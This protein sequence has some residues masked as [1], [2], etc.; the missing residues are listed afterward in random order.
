MRIRSV[1][2]VFEDELSCAT[3]EF[4][5]S[6]DSDDSTKCIDD[7]QHIDKDDDESITLNAE[8]ELSDENVES[9]SKEINLDNKEFSGTEMPHLITDEIVDDST[10]NVQTDSLLITDD[11]SVSFNASEVGDSGRYT[12]EASCSHFEIVPIIEYEDALL[13]RSLDVINTRNA[14]DIKLVERVDS[15]SDSPRHTAAADTN[16]VGASG[17]APGQTATGDE[18]DEYAVCDASDLHYDSFVDMGKF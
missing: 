12:E 3:L 6:D 4:V 14:S 10:T 15:N 2:I 18:D 7:L 1:E 5:P 11:I 8:A 9:L 16:D 13:S 17:A